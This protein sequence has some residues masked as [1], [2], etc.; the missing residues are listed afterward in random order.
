MLQT[1]GAWTKERREE[2]GVRCSYLRDVAVGEIGAGVASRYARCEASVKGR[3]RTLLDTT[4]KG[5]TKRMKGNAGEEAGIRGTDF[6]HLNTKEA[7]KS[8]VK[9]FVGTA[10]LLGIILRSSEIERL[11]TFYPI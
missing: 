2:S 4:Q 8:T 10:T 11:R 9:C 3:R 7:V 1:S 5:P 6:R